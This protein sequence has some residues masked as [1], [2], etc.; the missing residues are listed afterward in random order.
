MRL[1]KKLAKKIIGNVNKENKFFCSNE[2]VFSN[3]KNLKKGIEKMDNK[4]FSHHAQ[5]G[6][7]DFSNWVKECIGDVRLA[8]GLIGLS[9]KSS[10]K[11]IESRITYIERYLEK[12]A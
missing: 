8:D 10:S 6:K 5:K 9:K 4:I 7:N 11:K 12:K 2:E 1:N 3:L